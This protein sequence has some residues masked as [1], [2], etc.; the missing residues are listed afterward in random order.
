MR[1]VTRRKQRSKSEIALSLVA[2]RMSYVNHVWHPLSHL[3]GPRF[4]ARDFGVGHRGRLGD[5]IWRQLRKISAAPVV[6]APPLSEA[7][8]EAALKV[9]KRARHIIN[10]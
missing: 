3:W 8:R 1:H 9:E 5:R 7:V 2:W 10:T 4:A 6:R